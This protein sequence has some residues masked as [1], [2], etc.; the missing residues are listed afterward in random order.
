[1]KTFTVMRFTEWEALF[2]DEQLIDQDHKI[3]LDTIVRWARYE[4]M[5]LK[6]VSAKSTRLDK[7]LSDTGRALDQNLTLTDAMIQT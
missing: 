4:P 6:I 2:R 3:E 5:I 1:M 7:H